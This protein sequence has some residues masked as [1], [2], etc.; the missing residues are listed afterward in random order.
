MVMFSPVTLSYVINMY[1]MKLIADLNFSK[2][3]MSSWE[4]H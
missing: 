3:E 2:H 1:G 4:I